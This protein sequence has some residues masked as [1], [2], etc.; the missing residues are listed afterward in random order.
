MEQHTIIPSF[1]SST[2]AKANTYTLEYDSENKNYSLTITDT[3]NTLADLIFD[4]SEVTVTRSGNKYTFTS[5]EMITD[6][7][8]ITAQKDINSDTDDLLIWGRSGSQT[9]ITGV[10]DPVVFY[11]KIDTET[12]GTLK[13][14]KESEDEKVEGISFTI[15]GNNLSSRIATTGSDGT[16]E[17][18][19]LL[20]GTYTITEESIDKYVEQETQEITIKS[21]KTTT[22]SFSNILKKFNVTLTKSDSET[23]E[24]QGD[25][26]LEGAVYGIYDD[27]ELIDTYTTDENG[28][29]TT[30]YYI[31]GDNWTIKEITPS[32]GYNLD[33]TEY[34]VGAEA[35]NYTIELN[36]V[37]MTV[38]ED[39]IKGQISIVK[40]TDNGETGIETPEEGATFEIY[41]KSAG[42]YENAEGTEKE[43]IVCDEDGYAETKELPYGVY[44]VHQVSGWENSECIQDFEVTISENNKTYRYIINNKEFESYL[45]MV[46]VDADS[47][48]IVTLN[49]ATFELYK[50]NEDTE[51][52]EQVSCKS[53][54]EYITTWTTDENGYAYTE[55]K[56]KSGTYKIAEINI[57]T[58]YLELNE[59]LIFEISMNNS[60]IE[61]DEDDDA[62][63]TVTVENAKPT[64]TLSINKS[65]NLKEDVDT[66]LV[67][68]IDYTQ[69]S[70]E[71][72]ANEDIIDMADG[73]TIYENGETVGIYYLNEEGTLTIEDIPMGVYTLQEVATMSNLVLNNTVYDVIFKQEDTTTKVYTVELDIEN[74]TTL[75]EIS[76]QNIG[77]EEI[78]GATLQVIDENGDI[79]DEWVST[80]TQ[81]TIEGLV[82]G[83]TYTLHEEICVEGYVKATDQ[84]FTILN[85]GEVQSVVMIDKIIE[86]T[87]TDLTTGEELEGAEL[88]V[89]D[90]DGNI[91]D[92][93][94]STTEPHVISNLVEGETYILIEITA[95]YDYEIAESIQFT[96]SYDKETQLIEMKDMPIL[97]DIK[98]E[99][100]DD[101]TEEN[102]ISNE[103]VFGIYSDSGCTEII[104]EVQANIDEGT[105]LFEDLRYGT[106]YIRELQAPNGYYLSEQIVEI[107]I[108]DTGVYADGVSLEE[109]DGIYSFI[110][111]NTAIPEIQTG[112]EINYILIITLIVISLIGIVASTVLLKK[113]NKKIKED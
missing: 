67:D 70:F 92:E 61:Y 42:S 32:E 59:D 7:I 16:I 91:I 112:N 93:W 99:K 1:A 55:T 8:T 49:S 89:T 57:P 45:K 95:P 105:A 20:P 28:E 74:E 80:D 82:V 10:N 18:T 111:Y 108:D 85:T 33:E 52:W 51:E 47:G 58:G 29:L 12:Y 25:A 86:I 14:N 69:I 43:T 3:N 75:I 6:E 13:L 90:E 40:H 97:T 2:V 66:S 34:T 96:V 23:V 103:F 9:M 11:L 31:C 26:T 44:V 78:E 41:L 39:V 24:A 88:Q 35:E 19:D 63:I 79:I 38:K 94:T 15:A 71:L 46:K 4:E 37:D 104:N 22:V 102:I 110:Y 56:L 5:E 84:E 83:Q 100:V 17:I 30:D 72:I 101:V 64:G 81:H 36:T 68:N 109:T 98:V 76:K 107:V 113:K 73:S 53:G 27:G 21:G 106:Y 54:N 77:G 60:T 50:L 48:K 87:K 65:V 62:W